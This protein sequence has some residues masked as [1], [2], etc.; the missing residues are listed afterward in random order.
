MKKVK[1]H[2][3]YAGHCLS[4]EHHAIRGGRRRE[5]EFQALWGLIEH[6]EFGNVLYDTGYT[7]RFFEATKNYPNKIYAKI[8]KVIINKSD[9]VA[10]Q[11]KSNNID[12]KSINHVI[13]THFHADH[14]G[15]MKDFPNALFYCS[16]VALKHVMNISKSI[17]FSR[18]VLKSL[19]PDNLKD[20]VHI[21]EDHCTAQKDEILGK[22][23]DLFGDDSIRIVELPGHGA[24]QIGVL[25]E[26]QKR[27]YFLI[28]DACWLKKSYQEMI[29]PNPIVRLFFDSW[30]D[31][32]NSLAKV[33]RYYKDNPEVV[34]VPTHCSES[35]NPLVSSKIDFDVL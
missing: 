22:T 3:N 21:I 11:L 18:G 35:T 2:L 34:I 14:V 13:I 29:L 20:R 5:I 24:G 15:G 8:T 28:A 12:P 30:K 27:P 1:L 16:K 19:L 10:S 17:A 4:N 6:P 9:E 32:K 33:N 26:T 25:L 7:S 23:F 31:F